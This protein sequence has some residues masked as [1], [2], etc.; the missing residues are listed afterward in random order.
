MTSVSNIG[1][2]LIGSSQIQTPY[3][4]LKNNQ[5]QVVSMDVDY[6]DPLGGV[7]QGFENLYLNE[8]KEG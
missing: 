5:A 3:H 4:Q 6:A 7:Q 2:G 1:Q 8:R